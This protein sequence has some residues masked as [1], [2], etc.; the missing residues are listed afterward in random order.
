ME[1]ENDV[2]NIRYLINHYKDD[3]AFIIGNGINR[4]NGQQS[5]QD[6][7]LKIWNS[8]NEEPI[9]K[10]P[11]GISYTEFYDI[12]HIKYDKYVT[13]Q[14]KAMTELG[15]IAQTLN[16]KYSEV[17]IN[18]SVLYNEKQIIYTMKNFD[19][20]QLKMMDF[21][22]YID[23]INNQNKYTW[24]DILL[25]SVQNLIAADMEKWKPNI[26]HKTITSYIKSIN[27]P[28]LTTN[29]DT[30]LNSIQGLQYYK[31]GKM[32]FSR[33]NP[34]SAYYGNAMINPEDGFGIWNINGTIK[35]PESIKLG[36]SQY[37]ASINKAYELLNGSKNEET[38]DYQLKGKNTKLWKGYN[39]WLHLLFNKSLFIFGLTLDENEIFLRWLLIQRTVYLNQHQND[40][41]KGWYV[42]CKGKDN[43]SKGKKLFL[44]S[45]GFEVIEIHD[46][47]TIY[48]D[49]WR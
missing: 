23:L 49:V 45:V 16:K 28:I 41:H 40:I 11:Q 32:N 8:V 1:K 29:Y 30:N 37:M 22:K 21:S 34:W 35:Y 31:L 44:E 36:L 5:W 20:S 24:S 27:A 12:I 38:D 3:I 39:T 13:K 19:L 10:I 17:M 25:S 26:A 33:K 43:M 18:N 47:K 46:Y 14:Y 2:R 4:F 48:E 42:Y 7:L 15:N 6:I 9:Q